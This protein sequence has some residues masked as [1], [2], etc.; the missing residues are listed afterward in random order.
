[1]RGLEFDVIEASPTRIERLIVR[2]ADAQAVV[3]P[4]GASGP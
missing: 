2:L 3:L 1:V 4:V